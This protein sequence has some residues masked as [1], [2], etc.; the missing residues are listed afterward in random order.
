M[1]VFSR[2][3]GGIAT[4]V[5]LFATSG[6]AQTTTRASVDSAGVQ[7]G[8]ASSAPSISADGRYVAF[9]SDAT[10]LVPGDTNGT[11]DVFVHDAVTGSTVRVSLDSSGGELP[12]I[13]LDPAISGNG[14]R[15]A[16]SYG[17]PAGQFDVYVRDL[18]TG[19]TSLVSATPGNVPG[20]STSYVPA[21]SAGGR[22]VAFFSY[23]SDLVPGD[24][25]GYI[26]CF[27]RDLATGTTSL[28]SR[29]SAGVQGNEDV[30][31]GGPAISSNGRFVAFSSRASNLVTGDSNN[32]VDVFRRDTLTNTT[33]L[34]SAGQPFG[35]AIAEVSISGD[36]RIVVFATD[37]ALVAGDTNGNFDVYA[38]D[39]VAG[40]TTRV[41]VDSAGAQVS[42][43][44]VDSTISADGRCVAF[45]SNSNDLVP[46]D[47]NG[48]VDIFVRDLVAQRTTRASISSHGFE[49]DADSQTPAISADGS[50]VAFESAAT[51]LVPGD[52][53]AVSDVFEID[54]TCVGA[55]FT[56]CTAKT[57][58]LGCVPTIGS[59]GVP[60]TSGPDGFYVTAR[61][62]R[63]RKL[64]MLLW[65]LQQASTPYFG[66]TL[67]VQSP[68]H[69][70]P[71]QNS[72]GSSSGDD[73]TGAYAY[74][75]TQAYMAQQGLA[76]NSTVFAQYW[77]RDPGFAPPNNVGLTDGLHF[78]ICE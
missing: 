61:N 48:A 8:N 60:S 21:I 53:N 43:Y 71:G 68:I 76:A 19:Q 3:I 5:A 37:A 74:H 64:G 9:Q 15:V 2:R 32:A 14:R 42:G 75:F 54:R 51:N 25:G 11:T 4:S 31:S 56:Y 22:Y 49:G 28:V 59:I 30:G 1:R 35:S 50:R 36:G 46:G 78:T 40:T 44:C 72:G 63:N 34:V 12:G 45:R 6:A 62:V 23:A 73:C 65:S 26:D 55:I 10:N 70:T 77:S 13:S 58:S 67:C 57:N 69:R 66:G 20:N 24:V 41:S 33:E 18:G 39:M 38:R 16:F 7:A 47:S 52:T 29:N 27:V 17:Q